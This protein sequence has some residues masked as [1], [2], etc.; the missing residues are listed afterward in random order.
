VDGE[1]FTPLLNAIERG[2]GKAVELLIARGADPNATTGVKRNALH[3]AALANDVDLMQ[4]ALEVVVI[5][6]TTWPP[7]VLNFVSRIPEPS[8]Y[9]VWLCRL[10]KNTLSSAPGSKS[11]LPIK[12][13]K[14]E[15]SCIS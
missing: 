5:F 15:G 2:H 11:M 3:L 6:C 1:G 7:S 8:L 4:W 9:E 14:T 10:P 13:R 12:A